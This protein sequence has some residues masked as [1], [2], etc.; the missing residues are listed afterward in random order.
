[1]RQSDLCGRAYHEIHDTA[2]K[3]TPPSSKDTLHDTECLKGLINEEDGDDFP[4]FDFQDNASI[5]PNDRCQTD[6]CFPKETNNQQPV[7][8]IPN[9][10]EYH[11]SSKAKCTYALDPQMEGYIK[12]L[13]FL[14]KIQAPIKAFDE[15][16]QLLFELHT[17]RFN[18]S[19]YHKKRKSIMETLTKHQTRPNG[20][21]RM[22]YC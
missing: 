17:S 12:I 13:C 4:F 10:C 1:L 9:D 16:M 3:D 14:D 19:S 11:P 22:C 15:L 7:L 18:F 5:N 20:K 6:V 2:N 8:M 21:S